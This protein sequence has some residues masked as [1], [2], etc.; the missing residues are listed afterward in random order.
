MTHSKKNDFFNNFNES[1]LLD[2]DIEDV[3]HEKNVS[4]QQDPEGQNPRV[5]QTDGHPVGK[6]DHQ[7][8][9]RKGKNT[10]VRVVSLPPPFSRRVLLR[11]FPLSRTRQRLK[12]RDFVRLQKEGIAIRTP[13]FT[14]VFAPGATATP[15]LG[16]T[17]GRHVGKAWQRNRIK[18]LIREFYRTN[19]HLLRGNWDINIIVKKETTGWDSSRWF[20][21]LKTVFVKLAKH[22]HETICNS[23]SPGHP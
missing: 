4:T 3:S 12:H 21:E 13:S 20:S 16:I 6:T 9:P 2:M 23:G 11:R 14:V 19:N 22:P 10:P 1:I 17:V 18:R 7:P 8:P 5:S 15:R